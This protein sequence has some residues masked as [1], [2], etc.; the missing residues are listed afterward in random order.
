MMQ[1]HKPWERAADGD[2]AVLMIHGIVGTPR[3]FLFL[4]DRFPDDWSLFAM[5]LDGH[6]GDV[7]DF[8]HTSLKTWQAQVRRELT[9][10]GA[11]YRRVYIVAH[12]LGTLLALDA[13]PNGE[14]HVEGMLLLAVPLRIRLTPM[15][16]W[17]SMHVLFECVNESD[18]AMV[19]SREAYGIKPD[20]RLWR[21]LSWIPR[22]LEL[23]SIS[24]KVRRGI[25]TVTTPC[26]CIQS[27]RDEMVSPRAEKALRR[28]KRFDV[29]TLP[30][31]SHHHYPDP[32]RSE[33]FKAVEEWE[34][35]FKGSEK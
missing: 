3:H 12:S 9:A 23:F 6:G 14:Y 16:P 11:R 31:A 10:L 33:I 4:K 18:A 2:T 27:A 26:V 30:N 20:K 32:D 19:S 34:G 7:R 17:H 5:Q 13:V 15:A 21:Y 22:Y 24:R 25:E 29:R 8:A 1:R 35:Q 28:N